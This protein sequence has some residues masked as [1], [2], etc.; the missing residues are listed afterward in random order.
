MLKNYRL[1]FGGKVT[2]ALKLEYSKSKNWKDGKF[3]NLET[4][5]FGL[6]ISKIPLYIYKQLSKGKADPQEPLPVLPLDLEQFKKA[7][8]KT[9]IVWYG[10][11][12]ILLNMDGTIIL[13]DPM[14]GYNTT[15]IAPMANKRF[16][17]NTLDLIDNFPEIDVILLSHDH[18]DHLDFDSIKK[19]TG[20][21]KQFI[22][23][24]GLKRHLVR[25]GVS[26]ELITEMD[27]WQ[28]T[29]VSDIQLTFTPTRHF[30]GRRLRDRDQ[31]LWGGWAIKN[32]NE[33]IWFSGDGGYGNHFKEIGEKLGP[34][35]FGFMECGQYNDLWKI[36]H[37]FPDEAIK[38]AKDAQV[39]KIMPVHW[40]GFSLSFQHGWTEPA[41]EFFEE[42]TKNNIDFILPQLGQLFDIHS[43]QKTKWWENI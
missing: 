3:H 37:L 34:F 13:I 24:L 36:I 17:L 39:K 11:S 26:P 35:D 20:K 8:D 9:K 32:K 5:N 4:T 22:V 41:E 14:L 25:W 7:S 19:L 21:T 10:H 38:A 42:A 15:P 1:Q 2:K 28:Q 27:W 18:Y 40:C 29:N 23:A 43:T 16:S 12:A 33:N 30:S 31:S 6:P